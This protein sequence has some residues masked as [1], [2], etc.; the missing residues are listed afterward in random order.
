M[1]R[2]TETVVNFVRLFMLTI[3]YNLRCNH[4]MSTTNL[5]FKCWPHKESIWDI[6]HAI[7]ASLLLSAFKKE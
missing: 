1:L 4:K 3:C 5:L 6:F 2:V 7:I